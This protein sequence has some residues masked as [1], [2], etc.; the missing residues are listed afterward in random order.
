MCTSLDE[1]SLPI[2]PRGLPRSPPRR[3]C[4]WDRGDGEGSQGT[5]TSRP[6]RPPS[7]RWE[8]G[9]PRGL[10][11]QPRGYSK[12]FGPQVQGWLFSLRDTTV[13]RKPQWV[14]RCLVR[15]GAPWLCGRVRRRVTTT[16]KTNTGRFG[17]LWILS[18]YCTSLRSS[19]ENSGP[20]RTLSTPQTLGVISSSDTRPSSFLPRAPSVGSVH[21]PQVLPP[22]TPDPDRSSLV[23]GFPS[24][25]SHGR[26]VP[27]SPTVFPSSLSGYPRPPLRGPLR[28]VRLVSDLR[29]I[30]STLGSEVHFL[31][32]SSSQGDSD[33]GFLQAFQPFP[34]VVARKLQA[35]QPFPVL[36]VRKHLPSREG[37]RTPQ[38][39]R[40]P[41]TPPELVD[42]DSGPWRECQ[43]Y[44]GST[45]TQGPIG[46]H[47]SRS[48]LLFGR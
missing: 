15:K 33:P 14:V 4:G 7:G 48:Y 38:S 44:K 39:T 25:S 13:D 35:F 43:V 27:V 31:S 5:C 23:Q 11:T 19:L 2:G 1:R 24:S 36:T 12:S 46:S 20:T 45:R 22:Y 28:P 17:V 37:R 34:V 41:S 16:I 40:V 47:W 9:T 42:D 29:V 30:P 26:S 3:R 10:D 8:L 6:T 18:N 32:S 21:N